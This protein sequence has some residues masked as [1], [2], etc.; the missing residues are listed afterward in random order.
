MHE[1]S[2]A[3]NILDIALKTANVN[4]VD[5]VLRITIR[6]GQLRGIVPEQLKFCFGFV[7]KDT[8]AEDSELVVNTLPIKGTCKQCGDL[9]FVKE[10]SFVCPVCSSEKVEVIQGME[11][12][13]ENIEVEQR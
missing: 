8:I 2:L 10:Y 7:A 9:F 5:R 13:V 1:M 11:L 3:Q 4:G 12:L 6:A